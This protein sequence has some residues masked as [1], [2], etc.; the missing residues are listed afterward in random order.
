MFDFSGKT[1][2]IT[3]AA[4]GIGK[5]TA[6]YFFGCGANVVLADINEGAARVVAEALDPS[7]ERVSAFRYDAGA[8]VSAAEVV[9]HAVERHSGIDHLVSCAGIYDQQITAEMTDEAWRRT[10]AI[11]LDG[12]FF[13]VRSAIPV[14]RDNGA[15]VTL[16]SVAAH[17]G[18]TGG[19]AHYGASKGGVLALTR[20]LAKD[21]APRIRVNCVS[22]GLIETPMTGGLIGRMGEDIL[23]QILLRRYGKPSEIASVIAFLCSDAAS[24]VTG[25]TIIVSGGAYMG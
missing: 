6:E 11:N 21:L 23:K 19:H 25:E 22:P 12:V 8:S 4:S 16:A 18:G 13:L 7:G 9:A 14:L 5:A 15:I 3:G 17:V 1:A 2:L 20:G 24:F 10:I